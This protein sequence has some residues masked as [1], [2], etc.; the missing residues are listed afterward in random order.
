MDVL[1][2]S[3]ASVAS[4]VDSSAAD[5]APAELAGLP[6]VDEDSPVFEVQ[7]AQARTIRDISPT[8]DFREFLTVLTREMNHSRLCF[9]CAS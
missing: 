2:A 4:V 3:V 7:P 8:A 9:M 6:G 1:V 5:G